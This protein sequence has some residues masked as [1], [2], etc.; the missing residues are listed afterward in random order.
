[1]QTSKKLL[2]ALCAIFCA[3]SDVRADTLAE[4]EKFEKCL[5]KAVLEFD[6]LT[7]PASDIAAVAAAQ[8]S[9]SWQAVL[10]ANNEPLTKMDAYPSSAVKEAAL[11]VVLTV[12]REVAELKNS[13]AKRETRKPNRTM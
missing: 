9:P 11:R 4:M 2:I 3:F 10:L 7:S 5:R 13:G 12:R 8:C 6:D 1:M